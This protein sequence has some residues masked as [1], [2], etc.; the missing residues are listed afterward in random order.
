[1]PCFPHILILVF[2]LRL[3]NKIFQNNIL[4]ETVL[5]K[6]SQCLLLMRTPPQV[7]ISLSPFLPK[8][9]RTLFVNLP[10]NIF[11]HKLLAL[12]EELGNITRKIRF[13]GIL[14][15]SPEYS[16]VAHVL[17]LASPYL[18]RNRQKSANLLFK[19]KSK[20]IVTTTVITVNRL[21]LIILLSMGIKG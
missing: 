7:A 3:K 16:N 9:L 20:Q 2:Y 4:N 5:V 6:F 1:M 21:Y 15:I 18:S 10:D 19:V 14:Q 13:C 8:T 11:T 17:F 12:L